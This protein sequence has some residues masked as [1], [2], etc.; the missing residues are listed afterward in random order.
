MRFLSGLQDEG[1]VIQQRQGICHQLVQLRIAELQRGLRITGRELLPQEISDVIGSKGA[2]GKCLL[3]GSGHCFGAVL[4]DQLEKFA[5]LAGESA[6]G[7]GHTSKIRFDSFLTAVTDQQSDQAPLR[8]RAVSSGPM[9]EQFFLETLGTQ[10]LTTP[11]A[12]RVAND[13][14]IAVIKSHGGSIGFDGEMLTHEMRRGAVAIAVE[15]EA[16]VLMH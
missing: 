2:G 9:G 13:F 5:D 10:G 4:P 14:L 8:L 3:Q 16:K 7:V 1:V 6:I 15:L 12:A 11:P